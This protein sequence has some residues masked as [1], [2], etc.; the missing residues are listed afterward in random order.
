M[1]VRQPKPKSINGNARK[2]YR[3]QEAWRRIKRA[4]EEEFFLEVVTIAESIITDR[5][6]SRLVKVE[7][8]IPSAQNYSFHLLIKEWEKW[9]QAEHTIHVEKPETLRELI[10]QVDE[11]R[12]Q[13]NNVVHGIVKDNADSEGQSIEDFIVKAKKVA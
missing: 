5:L 4:Q 7:K 1:S 11:W 6:I 8:F 13:R 2:Y 12:K 10:Q 3:Y 9:L